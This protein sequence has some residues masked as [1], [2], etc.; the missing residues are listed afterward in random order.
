MGQVSNAKITGDKLTPAE[1]NALVADYLSQTD[2]GAQTLGAG[3]ST[4]DHAFE[5]RFD[6]ILRKKNSSYQAIYGGG[7]NQ[8]GKLLD[9][10]SDCLTVL[11]A[12]RDALPQ[13]ATVDGITNVGGGAVAV[14]G[15][16]KVFTLSDV[17]EID[18]PMSIIGLGRWA[19]TVFKLEDDAD[20]RMFETKP[21]PPAQ[22][23][24][25][26]HLENLRFEGNKANQSG[27]DYLLYLDGEYL[28]GRNIYVMDG[29]GS[30]VF[31]SC[32]D[33]HLMNWYIEYCNTHGWVMSFL[34]NTQLINCT[35]WDNGQRGFQFLGLGEEKHTD[36]FSL[37][38]Q[39][40][41]YEG[42]YIEGGENFNIW[43]GRS[44]LN[45]KD[46]LIIYNCK[47]A[48]VYGLFAYNNSQLIN[49]NY[50]GIRLYDSSRCLVHGVKSWWSTV[51]N[52]QKYGIV[53]EGT[54]DKNVVAHSH[55]WGN[56]TD[57]ILTIGANTLEDS[58][59]EG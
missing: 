10:D 36:L 58:N 27:G 48:S 59:I 17:F 44:M 13:V 19:Q 2:M 38:A 52:K 28:T 7:A 40:N 20:S 23:G 25:W 51:A 39:N 34:Q 24:A 53:E 16:G 30:G 50:S 4:H 57:D 15:G 41:G 26:T 47:R 1:F 29:Y 43:G 35:A 42:I 46:G 6:F 31:M 37:R 22:G 32:Q 8:A 45:D 55:A 49:N 56:Q 9:S 54:S 21:P 33:T 12:I 5:K 14:K 3:E 18:R 11:E